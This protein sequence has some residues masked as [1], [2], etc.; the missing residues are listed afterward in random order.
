MKA[1]RE[2]NIYM[3][4]ICGVSPQIT[5]NHVG[6]KCTFTM[7]KLLISYLNQMIKPSIYLS[8]LGI[9]S[10]LISRNMKS[11][12]SLKILKPNV[13]PISQTEGK[14]NYIMKKQSNKSSMCNIL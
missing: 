1:I 13:L 14:L 10:F 7:E 4:L 2:E 3:V 6:G 12:I 11:T 5:Q 9:I 8:Q